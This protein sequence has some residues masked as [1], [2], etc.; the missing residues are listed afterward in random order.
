M[1]I[2][3]SSAACSFESR[4]SDLLYSPVI[5]KVENYQYAF[6]SSGKLKVSIK[7]VNIEWWVQILLLTWITKEGLKTGTQNNNS[8]FRSSDLE[9]FDR[10][11]NSEAVSKFWRNIF[12]SWWQKI[13]SALKVRSTFTS[14]WAPEDL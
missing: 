2:W 14:N 12:F 13:L 6:F 9:I 5:T 4:I 11:T 1:D 7:I 3:T 10:A 8:R